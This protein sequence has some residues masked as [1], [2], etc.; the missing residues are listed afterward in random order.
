MPHIIGT[1]DP[2]ASIVDSLRSI[3]DSMY[4]PVDPLTAAILDK[5]QRESDSRA[6]GV[7]ALRRGD[8]QEYMAN[9]ILANQSAADAITYAQQLGYQRLAGR[10]VGEDGNPMPT[11]PPAPSD[12]NAPR[13]NP[14]TQPAPMTSP[15][16]TVAAPALPSAWPDTGAAALRFAPA[17]GKLP[18]TD[19]YGNPIAAPFSPSSWSLSP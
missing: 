4:R 13:Y 15:Q 11:L 10:I 12:V 9:S 2:N 6:K 14:A 3:G 5:K 18:N 17:P 19:P 1:K 8:M 16:P 7:D